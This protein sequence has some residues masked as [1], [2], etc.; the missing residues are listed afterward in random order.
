MAENQSRTQTK[1]NIT[2]MAEQRRRRR[3]KDPMTLQTVEI[4]LNSH[5]VSKINRIQTTV[6]ADISSSINPRNP[7]GDFLPF[8][9]ISLFL[10]SPTLTNR[11]PPLFPSAKFSIQT[12]FR[13]FSL[14]IMWESESEFVRG[15]EYGSELLSPTKHGLKADGFEQRGRSWLL[16]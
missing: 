5:P 7:C 12:F 14:S 15:R 9:F 16:L 11:L 8:D 6:Q 13:V 3:K 10:F 2:S 1:A 4:P